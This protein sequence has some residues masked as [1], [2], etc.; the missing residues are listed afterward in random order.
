ME[1]IVTS[2]RQS[3]Q[4]RTVLTS[5]LVISLV[6]SSSILFSPLSIVHASVISPA[7]VLGGW[8]GARLADT[9]QNPTAPDSLVFPGERQSNFEQIA[10][11]EFQ[12]GYNT[13]RASFAPY[14]SVL[15]GLNTIAVPQDFIGNYSSVQL[16]RAIKIAEYFS[17]WIVVDYHGYTDLASS[18]LVNCWSRFWFGPNSTVSG[19]T[20]VVGAFM[21]SYDRIVWEPLNEPDSGSFPISGTSWCIENPGPCDDNETLY[22]SAQYQSWLDRDRSM[23]D[24]H[25]V[26]VQNMCSFGCY[27]SRD[28][29]YLDY[30]MVNDPV[31][32][33]F[34]SFHTYLNYGIATTAAD[35]STRHSSY[36]N[37]TTADIFAREDYLTMLNETV[38]TSFGWPVLNTEGGTSC[39]MVNGTDCLSSTLAIATGSAGY[40]SISLHYIQDMINYED[41]NGP[42]FGWIFWPAASWTNTPNGGVYGALSSGQW[43]TLIAY[44]RFEAPILVPSLDADLQSLVYPWDGNGFYTQGRHWIF[45][46][47]WTSCGGVYTSCLYYATSTNGA[48]WNVNNIGVATSGTTSIV[49]NGT[50]VFYVRYNGTN[51]QLGR[52]LMFRDGTLQTNG[53]ISWQPETIVKP[54]TLGEIWNSLSMRVSTTGQAFVAYEEESGAYSTGY[55]FVI[56]SNGTN[57]SQWQQDTPLINRNDDWR[58]SLVPLP[59]GQM[60]LLYWPFWGE[61]RGRL[62]TN[63]T[64]APEDAV[65]PHGT[66]VLQNAFGF[67]NGN[68]TVY[69]IWQEKDTQKI[70]FSLRTDSWNPP[71]TVAIADTNTNPVWTA[72]YDTFQG[73][74]YVICYNY[75]L[76]QVYQ[77]SG[78]PGNWSQKTGLFTTL[79]GDSTMIVGSYYDTGQINSSAYVLGIY[80]IKSDSTLIDS[81]FGF[82]EEYIT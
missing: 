11:R 78:T 14:C 63:G 8:G 10:L 82:A 26:V 35:G 68:S 4:F 49:T 70:Q 73:K 42:R 37:M 61:L 2:T 21:N 31:G 23:G 60:Y 81:Q 33:V 58:F 5:V 45:Y 51:S 59:A 62:Y 44:Q 30:P 27:K 34:A 64:W 75:T 36:W 48:N 53:T 22:M 9:V 66:Y 25:W 13:V 7:P 1:I 77:Y 18:T 43:G 29:Y 65:T 67:S 15:Y 16:S 57:Y 69:A 3:S 47:N 12:L 56:Q 55:P 6:L 46:L 24:G 38:R 19:P 41:S 17:M 71:Q 50:H 76:D 54:A 79:G 72:S 74:W 52:A 20:G 28:K 80:W 39:G 32:R 40:T